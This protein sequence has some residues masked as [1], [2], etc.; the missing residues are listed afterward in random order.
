MRRILMLT[1]AT[2]SAAVLLQAAASVTFILTNGDRATG[3]IA[4]MSE[5]S[6]AMP[7]GELNL[8][9]PGMPERS[10]GLE[11]VAVIDFA[12]GRPDV[13]ELQALPARG[14]MLALRNGSRT[15]GRMEDLRNGTLR[16]RGASGSLEVYP[17]DQIA[18]IYLDPDAARRVYEVTGGR[19]GG[20]RTPAGGRQPDGSIVVVA[21]RAWTDTGIQVR[22][23]QRFRFQ[24]SGEIRFGSG[25]DQVAGPD[26]NPAVRGRMFPVP[27]LPVGGLIARVNQDPPMSV[28]SAPQAIT[29]GRGG[30]LQL[31]INDNTFDDNSGFFRV[32]ITPVR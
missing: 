20:G 7:M 2:V 15:I 18:R 13:Q 26:G 14:Q 6:P 27:Q 25:A 3:E 32:V 31:G 1:L 10:F 22:P 4:S 23:G 29:F 24:V 21:N 17:Q 5:A 16:W 30:R 19:E 28:G 8:E 11:M 9:A 12:G